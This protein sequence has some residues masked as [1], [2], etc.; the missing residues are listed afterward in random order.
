MTAHRDALV[1]LV[2]AGLAFAAAPPD[3]SEIALPLWLASTTPFLVRSD[4]VHRRL[5][6]VATLPALALFV[7][8]VGA[9]AAAVA[10]GRGPQE[11][12]PTLLPPAT[13]A[14]AGVAAAR[15]GRFG[16]GDVKLATAVAGS[17]AQI[18]PWLLLVVAAVASAAALACALPPV[19]AWRHGLAPDEPA[20]VG[21][22]GPFVREPRSPRRPRRSI[23][24][25][26]PLLAGYW[27]AVGIVAFSP[28]GSC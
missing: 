23:A 11:A 1:I 25:G 26:P 5:P 3:Q 22:E 15:R 10:A 16:M 28:G 12:L 18:A 6:N 17:I 24:F 27:C 4:V 14:V 9:E 21:A 19:F 8:S 7:A 20:S 13:V 2:L